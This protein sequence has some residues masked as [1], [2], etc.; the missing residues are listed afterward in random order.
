MLIWEDYD[1]M[2]KRENA[3]LDNLFDSVETDKIGVLRLKEGEDDS[4]WREAN[5]LLPEAKSIIV[6]A[7][8][9]FSE[10]VKHLTS[11]ARVGEMMLRDL[12][13]RNMYL[14]S[15]HLDWETYKLVKK[16]HKLGFK[17]VPLPAGDGPFDGRYLKSA[18]SYVNT[19]L[20]AGLGLR[21]WHSMLLTP[22]YGPRVRLACIITDAPVPPVT[23]AGQE[24][25]CIKCG[26]ACVKICP[27]SAISK[28]EGD[29]SHRIDKYLCST[30]L[31]SS[32]GCSECLRVCPAGKMS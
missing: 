1:C 32:G 18:L 26:G 25:P 31:T 8:E 19:A 30:Y 7:L 16:L 24:L 15:G 13:K 4:L 3:A 23:S 2:E 28:P 10:V 9:V 5:A 27:V 22:D 6:L 12:A 20:A 21:G 29:E 11:Q 14:V 17:G